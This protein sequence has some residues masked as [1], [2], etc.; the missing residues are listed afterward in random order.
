[1]K[2]IRSIYSVG[3]FILVTAITGCASYRACPGPGCTSDVDTTAAVNAAIASHADLGP[4]SQIQVSTFNHVVYLTGLVDTGYQREVA[5]RLAARSDGGAEV[6]NSIE[7]S[8]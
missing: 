3:T 1:M 8:N 4:P 5:E 2:R 7:V 6:V